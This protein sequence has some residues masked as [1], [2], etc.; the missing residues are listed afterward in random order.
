MK[1]IAAAAVL[2][3]PEAPVNANTPVLAPLLR[4]EG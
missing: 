1:P 2:S 4:G 3:E